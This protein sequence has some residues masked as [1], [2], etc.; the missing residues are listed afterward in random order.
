MQN[1]I[2]GERIYLRELNQEDTSP[3][4]CNWLNDPMV[5]EFLET[6]KTTIEELK[7]YV[8]EK[9]ENSNCL[10]LGIFL[11]ENNKHIGNIKLEPIDFNNKRATIG[12][13]IGNKD[14]WGKGIATE[15]TRLLVNYAFNSLDLKEVNLGVISE[16]KA[17]IKVYKKVGFQI[18]RIEKKS[19]MYGN[20]YYD[21]IIMSINKDKD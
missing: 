16:N 9:K 3:E 18:D 1:I 8:K 10:F 2:N 20:K 15:A 17:A 19:T 5:N 11:K 14:Y 21:G 13:L 7:Q 6:K 4:Y 12:I